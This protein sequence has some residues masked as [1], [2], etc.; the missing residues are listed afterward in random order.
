MTTTQPDHHVRPYELFVLGISVLSIFIL[1]GLATLKAYPEVHRVLQLADTI[2]A[3]AFLLDF[4]YTLVHAPDKLKY[5]R[6]WGWLDLL[7]SI[8]TVSALRVGRLARIFRLLRVVRG[9]KALR[10]VSHAFLERRAESTALAAVVVTILVLTVASA[11]VLYFED[12]NTANIRSA[13]DAIWWGI[14][15]VSTVGYGD[16]YP[17]S[18]EGRLVGAVLMATGVGLFGVLSGLMASWFLKP[19]ASQHEKSMDDLHEAIEA[20]RREVAQLNRPAP[21][22]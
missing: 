13:E 14:T 18:T 12:P 5:M 19:K 11:S 4:G 22:S 15:T 3:I 7:S 6:T 20:L 8:P 9:F 10:V 17:M 2:I 21:R 1:A 16:K